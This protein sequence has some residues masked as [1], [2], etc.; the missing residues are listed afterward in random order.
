MKK[1]KKWNWKITN[2]MKT[3]IKMNYFNKGTYIQYR[4]MYFQ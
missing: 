3:K 4:L 1:I 2:K